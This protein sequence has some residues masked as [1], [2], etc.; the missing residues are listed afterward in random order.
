MT[1]TEYN[2]IVKNWENFIYTQA[3]KYAYIN[4]LDQM[5][6][7]DLI[8]EGYI[9]VFDAYQSYLTNGKEG[10]DANG[11]IKAYIN[12]RIQTYCNRVAPTVK[13][14]KYYLDEEICYEI[15]IDDDNNDFDDN[16]WLAYQLINKE[17]D[18]THYELIKRYYG[19][20]GEQK[21]TYEELAEWFTKTYHH[22]I[23]PEKIQHEIIIFKQRLTRRIRK[24]THN[25]YRKTK[26]L[27]K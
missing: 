10:N 2:N 9:A 3:F 21:M 14:Q 12:G 5:T 7:Q 15:E 26:Y 4:N 17:K 23:T 1:N 19:L 13:N 24:K 25:N 16:D 11:L 6:I 27:K 18:T 20:D 8:Q 22:Y